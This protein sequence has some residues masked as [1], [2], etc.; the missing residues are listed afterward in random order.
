MAK[1][2]ANPHGSGDRRVAKSPVPDPTE[3][4]L[5]MPHPGKAMVGSISGLLV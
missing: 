2:R 5:A 4:V 1:R 3:D